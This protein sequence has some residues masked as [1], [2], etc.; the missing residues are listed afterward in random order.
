MNIIFES[1]AYKWWFRVDGVK[2]DA[3]RGG[4]PVALVGIARFPPPPDTRRSPRCRRDIHKTRELLIKNRHAVVPVLRVAEPVL[5]VV[6][7]DDRASRGRP[8]REAE[9][10][11]ARVEDQGV[12]T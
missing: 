4:G 6:A 9:V 12:S 11:D 1:R 7:V 10:Q 2:V 3:S 8:I 5:R